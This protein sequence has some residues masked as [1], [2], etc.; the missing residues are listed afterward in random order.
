MLLRDF[1]FSN[2]KIYRTVL[3]KARPERRGKRGFALMATLTLLMLLSMVAMGILAITISQNRIASHVV[4]QAEARQQALMGLDAALSELQLLVGPDQRVTASSGIL[5]ESDNFPQHILGVWNSWTAP[6]YGK[7]NGQDIKQTYS[8]G[9]RSMFRRWL[10][11]SRDYRTLKNMQDVQMLSDRNPGSRVCL[12]G[13]GTMGRGVSSGQFIYADLILTPASG[14]NEGC[15]AWWVGGENQK[16]NAVV[17]NR[18]ATEDPVET[19]HR[20]WDTPAPHFADTS[21]LAFLNDTSVAP[22][23][24]LSLR[25][26]PL[27]GRGSVSY[28]TPYFF[29]VTTYSYSLPVNVREGGVKHDLNLLLNKSSL[30]GTEFARRTNQDCPIVEGEGVP[31]GT[32]PNMPIG[33]WQVMHAYYHTWPDGMKDD[34]SGFAARLQGTVNQA[35]TLMSGEL[36]SETTDKGDSVTFY[37]TRS[38]ENDIQAGYARTPVLTAFLGCWGLQ[39]KP[40]DYSSKGNALHY[41]YSPMAMW[42]NPYNVAMHVGAKKLWL[43]PLPYR[44]TSVQAWDDRVDLCPTPTASHWSPR[45][46]MHTC[47]SKGVGIPW[48]H[49]FRLDWGNY[50]VTSES[51]QSSEIIFEPGEIIA[52]TLAGDVL[53]LNEVDSYGVPHEY[54]FIIGDH[55]ER[56]THFRLNFQEYVNL[57]DPNKY[58]MYDMYIDRFSA[59][60]KLEHKSTPYFSGNIAYGLMTSGKQGDYFVTMGEVRGSAAQYTDED[61]TH[62]IGREA[63]AITYGYDGLANTATSDAEIRRSGQVDRFCGAK[64]ISPTS[65]MLGWYD[66]E[67]VANEDLVFLDEKWALDMFGSEPV[68]YKAVGIVPKSYNQSF[69]EGLPL[70]RGKDYRTKSWQHSSPAFWGS[71]LNKPDEQQRQYHP[72]QLAVLD[73]GSALDRGVLDTVNNKNGVFGITSVGA[74]GGEGVSFLSVLELPMHP[75][76]SLAGFAG[77]RLTPGWY[78]TNGSGNEKSFA[79][80]RRVQYQAG[81]PGVG[82]GNSF[83]DPCLPADDVYVYHESSLS[84]V[85]TSNA[86]LFSDFFDHGLLINDALW[87]RWFCSSVS[88][89][90]ERAGKTSAADVLTRFVEGEAEL[91]V[92]RYKLAPT[93]QS[94]KDIVK[95]ILAADGWKEIARYLVIEGGFNVNSTSED[96]WYA[97]LLGL[98]KRDLVHNAS[99]NLQKVTRQHDE[100]VLFSRFMVSTCSVGIDNLGYSPLQGSG[101]LRPNLKMAAA[102][103]EVRELNSDQIR[104][105]AREMVKIVRRRG[106][107]LNMSDFINRRLDG[108]SKES[109][110]GALQAAIDATDINDIFK[111]AGFNI[112]PA[113]DG[114]LYRYPDAESGSMYTAAPGYLIQSDVLMSL[115]NICTV[116]DDTFL[117]RS[118][119]CVRNAGKAVLAQAWCEAV[120]QRTMDYVDP[121]NTALDTPATARQSRS[122]G[123]SAPLSEINRIMGRKLKVVSFRWLDAW[124]I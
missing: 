63:Y 75:P 41:T 104:E 106:P 42:W 86:R 122:A 69:N 89:M 13:E 32:E 59:K 99:M 33:S 10:I 115:G 26:L 64:G 91:P 112:K 90:P 118:Y 44:T 80:A 65:F 85:F 109:L 54:P 110:C 24:L 94:S 49:A 68:Y 5:S 117:V 39:A 82:I 70:M 31:V 76:F 27:V 84:S 29:D 95:R 103:G 61:H 56:M 12:V 62:A 19:L 67:T 53:S 4:L 116:R 17:R 111:N 35:Y 16:A 20:T 83:A 60:L 107:F 81:V 102:W 113:E 23:K 38:K 7:T 72:Y 28:G 93:Q 9:R 88:D 73:M 40:S 100:N 25:T 18:Q 57:S 78:E 34:N 101:G 22:E 15:F 45:L 47:E 98:S 3:K 11:S 71:A 55:P 87:D 2:V 92:S 66:Y 8:E 74:G 48:Q 96:A 119:G 21:R 43:F 30:S 46:I 120:V 108:G 37:D 97:V 50:F 58:T 51:D 14:K 79:R 52:F 123:G 124:D 105:L 1:F 114:T 6:L 77:M 36:I 121:T